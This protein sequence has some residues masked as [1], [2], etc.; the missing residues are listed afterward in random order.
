MYAIQEKHVEETITS[1]SHNICPN[2]AN[3]FRISCQLQFD[4]N[5]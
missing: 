1:R 4:A 3:K 2:S 5:L